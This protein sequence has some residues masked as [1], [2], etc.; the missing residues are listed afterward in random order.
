MNWIPCDKCGAPKDWAERADN[1]LK[2][3]IDCVTPVADKYLARWETTEKALRE[4][5]DAHRGS[6]HR[7]D[8]PVWDALQKAH[9]V[10]GDT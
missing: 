5:V 3:G 8:S 6:S 2:A 9:K 1:A 7:L 10:L 4:L